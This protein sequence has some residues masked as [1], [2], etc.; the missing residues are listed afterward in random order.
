MK[1]I[2]IGVII[3]KENEKVETKIKERLEQIKKTKLKDF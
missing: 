1:Y 2:K 3:Y